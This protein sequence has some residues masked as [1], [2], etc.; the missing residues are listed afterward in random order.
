M[1][2]KLYHVFSSERLW[3]LEEKQKALVYW[4]SL[5]VKQ[6]PVVGHPWPDIVSLVGEREGLT[7]VW[8]RNPHD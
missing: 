3:T 4:L 5:C 6:S 1:D 8:A 7:G 2:V